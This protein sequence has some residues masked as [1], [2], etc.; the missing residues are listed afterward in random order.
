M[1]R[2]LFEDLVVSSGHEPRL[3]GLALPVS[4]A[5]HA[6]LL[7][8]ALVVPMVTSDELPLKP[9]LSPIVD[10]VEIRLPERPPRNPPPRPVR[11]GSAHA[12]PPVGD[13]QQAAV[14]P[15][16]APEGITDPRDAIDEPPGCLVGC[17]PPGPIGGGDEPGPP[18]APIQ[19][20]I[21]VRG[22]TKIHHV[23]PVYPELAKRAR[24]QGTVVLE[25]T[26]GPDG[27]VADVRVLRGVPFLDP[28][29]IEAVRQ[30]VYTPTLLNGVPVSVILTVTVRFQ[31]T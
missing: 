5:V 30:W 19:V 16:D 9:V 3:G 15:I 21:G 2:R 23:D 1:G 18:T 12:R 27:R 8:A 24:V 7:I 17:A 31:L 20:G 11:G 26:L 22:P 13:R 4:A 10:V 25:C 14:V 28:A 29:A 6:A